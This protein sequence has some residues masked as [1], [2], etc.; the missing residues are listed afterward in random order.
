M[1]YILYCSFKGL[2]DFPWRDAMGS[3]GEWAIT[4]DIGSCLMLHLQYYIYIYVQ[5][6]F[7]DV[8]KRSLCSQQS[9]L[10]DVVH[11]AYTWNIIKPSGGQQISTMREA[12]TDSVTID[13]QHVYM[14][15]CICIFLRYMIAIIVY[16]I[17]YTVGFAAPSLGILTHVFRM[18]ST[19]LHS[20]DVPGLGSSVSL[21]IRASHMT[22]SSRMFRQFK[23]NRVKQGFRKLERGTRQFRNSCRPCMSLPAP[24]AAFLWEPAFSSLLDAKLQAVQAVDNRQ[25][26]AIHAIWIQMDQ[27]DI[28]QGC[29]P[30][31]RSNWVKHSSRLQ[32]LH[33]KTRVTRFLCIFWWQWPQ[34]TS[35]DKVT[36]FIHILT[37]ESS[38]SRLISRHSIWRT[39]M[40]FLWNWWSYVCS[41]HLESQHIEPIETRPQLRNCSRFELRAWLPSLGTQPKWAWV[42]WL[43]CSKSCCRSI[44]S[45]SQAAPRKHSDT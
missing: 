36:Y 37:W 34:A 43:P 2:V 41:F 35:P 23:N 32:Q 1:F 42:A 27:E 30:V 9:G 6:K 25:S 8:Q 4:V 11:R 38:Q 40:P 14:W 16:V 24:T 15:Y 31:F 21:E 12:C 3:H 13:M 20:H 19:C 18:L 39:S 5:I 10:R 7:S 29:P 44:T 22:S 33:V 28:M 17:E 26:Q 45:P